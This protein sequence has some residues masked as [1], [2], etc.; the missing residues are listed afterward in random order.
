MAPS[1]LEDILRTHPGVKDV[2]VIGGSIFFL[3]KWLIIPL[4]MFNL[5]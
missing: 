1:E 2:A 5:K 3:N 4:Y